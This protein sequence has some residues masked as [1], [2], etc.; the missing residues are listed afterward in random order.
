MEALAHAVRNRLPNRALAD[1]LDVIENIVEHQV[2]LRVGA[3]PVRRVQI[4]TG[5]REWFG[6]HP[7]GK[8]SLID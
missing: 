4:A 1:I 3:W 2:P 8:F 7:A 5:N 6:C